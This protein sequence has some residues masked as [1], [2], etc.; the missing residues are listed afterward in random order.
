MHELLGKALWLSYLQAI[1]SLCIECRT[2]LLGEN[3]LTYRG[4]PNYPETVRQDLHW[5]DGKLK[6]IS[7][8]TRA[9]EKGDLSELPA[10]SWQ[11][12]EML[13]DPQKLS[14]ASGKSLRQTALSLLT[15]TACEPGMTQV[16]RQKLE[17][18]E[19]GLFERICGFFAQRLDKDSALQIF[20][21]THLLLQI[22]SGVTDQAVTLQAVQLKLN[23]LSQVVP[24]QLNQAL[25][26]LGSVEVKQTKTNELIRAQGREV[27]GLIKTLIVS[28]RSE[29][30]LNSAEIYRETAIVSSAQGSVPNPF[31]PLGGRIKD[32]KLLF[33]RDSLLRKIFE[34]LN[35][36]SNVALIGQ[37]QIGKSSMLEAIQRDIQKY[38]KVHRE[39]IYLDLQH[40]VDEDDFYYALCDQVGIEKSKGYR[41]TR[42]LEPKRLLLLLD[43]LEKMT[44]DGF[45]NQVREHL[46][47]LAGER[48]APIKMVVAASE[49]LDQLFATEGITSP[50]EGIYLEEKIDPWDEPIERA[51]IADRLQM[52]LVRFSEAEV[53]Q[54]VE[55]CQGHPWQIIRHC[56]ACYERYQQNSV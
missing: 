50:V 2:E 51:F 14:A 4:Q 30:A 37:A 24:Q 36:G 25:Q 28:Q 11:S 15:D 47:G 52:T 21:E 48:D 32:P 9:V 46:R 22:N 6:Q 55:A 27:K 31:G 8:S 41:L 33:G 56:Y 12:L 3:E 26:T 39:P 43:G 44:L 29:K 38:L 17:Q 40:I 7:Q 20:F 42:A 1:Q 5:L 49:S 54:I 45:S 23:G 19:T 34:I 10:F 35:S 13:T 18:S 16:Y 53:L